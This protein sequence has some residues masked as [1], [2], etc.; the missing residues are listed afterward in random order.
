MEANKFSLIW[1]LVLKNN[2]LDY[3]VAFTNKHN[4]IITI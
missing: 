2:Y 3:I 4:H 1:K